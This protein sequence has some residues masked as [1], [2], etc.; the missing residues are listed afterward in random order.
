MANFTRIYFRDSTITTIKQLFD[1]EKIVNISVQDFLNVQ[2]PFGETKNRDVLFTAYTEQQKKDLGLNTANDIQEG[3]LIYPQA[4]LYLPINN[5]TTNSIKN[6]SKFIK[7]EDYDAFLANEQKKI[8]GGVDYVTSDVIKSYPQAN[9]WIWC[10]S[11][12]DTNTDSIVGRII[13]L[14]DF[15]ENL[16]TNVSE[17]GGNFSIEIPLIPAKE[18]ILSD[19]NVNKQSTKQVGGWDFDLLN[20]Y[21]Y[22]TNEITERIYKESIHQNQEGIEEI[23]D[24]T[25]GELVVNKFIPS[26]RRDNLPML[27][28]SVNDIVFIKLERL[29]NES[30]EQVKDLYVDPRGLVNEVFDMV[31]LVDS[32]TVDTNYQ[33]T[34]IKIQGRDLMKLILDDGTFFFPNS[35]SDPNAQ[36]GVFINQDEEKGDGS[37]T[38]NKLQSILKGSVDSTSRFIGTGLI[39]PWYN[40][41]NRNIETVIDTLIKTLANIQICPDSLF[42]PYGEKRTRFNKTKTVKK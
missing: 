2:D 29:R 24:K 5:A 13:N 23:F 21:K 15:L 14:T 10:K 8:V 39:T 22:Q 33:N 20:S 41:W 6:E 9:V 16:S 34:T 19:P 32:V 37:N 40:A 12:D 27:G 18:R 7:N 17:T 1:K 36:A 11:L 26:L 38:T 42:E 31:G 35:T 4:T 28:V 30:N 25:S 3:T